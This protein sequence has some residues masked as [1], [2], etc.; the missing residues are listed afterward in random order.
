LTRNIGT[1]VV[2]PTVS[3]NKNS[4]NINILSELQVA[5]W[6]GSQWKNM[7]QASLTGN[8]QTGTIKAVSPG[9]NATN[10]YYTTGNVPHLLVFDT[11]GLDTLAASDTLR[12]TVTGA[13]LT[14][15]YIA[16]SIQNLYPT[17]PATG[18]VSTITISFTTKSN[19][20][21]VIEM[22][23]TPI[24]EVKNPHIISIGPTE[25]ACASGCVALGTAIKI[26]ECF[27]KNC[28]KLS[29]TVYAILKRELD[30]GYFKIIN[31]DFRFKFEEEYND[32]DGK[33]SYRLY[34]NKHELL[35]ISTSLASWH[36]Y[37]SGYG[38][39]YFAINI[40][41]CYNNVP[42]GDDYYTIEVE[43][44]KKEVWIARV[45][46]TNVGVQIGCQSQNPGDIF[47]PQ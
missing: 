22:K 9:I 10:Q 40:Q 27:L 4:C 15:T 28:F 38:T 41:G 23:L 14:G 35:L 16:G 8:V 36:Q 21:L 46:N 12:Y 31:G 26:N 47:V 24:G 43:N 37:N 45:K 25:P 11:R 18:T 6:D 7:G 17:L 44:E 20:S 39:M 30:G 13:G 3:W 5:G 29:T 2:L 33:L 42:L 19:Q 32:S 1:S 34:N